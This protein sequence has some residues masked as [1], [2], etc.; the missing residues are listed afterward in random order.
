MARS[1][2][3]FTLCG[4]IAGYNGQPYAMRN[5][6]VAVSKRLRL[7]GFIV[8][9]HFNAMPAFLK[10]MTGWIGAKKITSAQTVDQGIENAVGAFL[11]LF[12]GENL[13][14]MLVKLS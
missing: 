14:K 6:G 10:E 9:D 13:G 7:E 2:A 8:S 4:M 12:T 3:R 11:K 1:F 5:L